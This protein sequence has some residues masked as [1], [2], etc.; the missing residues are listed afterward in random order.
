VVVYGDVV[1]VLEE[2]VTSDFWWAGVGIEVLP[3]VVGD[4]GFGVELVAM[5][6]ERVFS[7]VSWVNVGIELLPPVMEDE[8]ANG[9]LLDNDTNW[10]G[11]KNVSSQS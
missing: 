9:E 8:G 4:E 10:S 2:G 11:S 5:V 3:A 6:E 7:V 1:W